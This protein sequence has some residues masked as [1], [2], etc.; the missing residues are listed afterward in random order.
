MKVFKP[1]LFITIAAL[2]L[3]SFARDFKV[4][5]YDQGN[6]EWQWAEN[7]QVYNWPLMS[8]EIPI[9]NAYFN[10]VNVSESTYRLLKDECPIGTVPQPAE[11]HFSTWKVFHVS[12]SSR[13]YFAPGKRS[14]HNIHDHVFLRFSDENLKK[15]LERIENTLSDVTQIKAYKYSFVEGD[16][17]PE[18]GV[19]AQELQTIYPE[20]V[21]MDLNSGYLKVDYKGMIPI[22]I[23]SIK[24]LE[25]RVKQ[26]ESS[27]P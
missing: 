13:S 3:P 19:I 14:Y 16:H 17:S 27:N 18:I 21:H 26:L 25:Q 24:E 10:Y 12:N 15:N 11:S 2:S 8:L 6:D 9:E 22:L 20:L 1:L 5:C 7:E 23:E 4:F